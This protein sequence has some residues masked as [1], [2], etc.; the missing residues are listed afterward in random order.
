[1]GMCGA[2]VIWNCFGRDQVRVFGAVVPFFYAFE[3]AFS[4]HALQIWDGVWDS[5]VRKELT[6]MASAPV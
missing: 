6:R 4:D 5:S 1:M 3:D 2:G